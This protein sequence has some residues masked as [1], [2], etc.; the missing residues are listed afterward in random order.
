MATTM[1]E[2]ITE[3]RNA[4]DKEEDIA[5]ANR[6]IRSTHKMKRLSQGNLLFLMLLS[7]V[8]QRAALAADHL[9]VFAEVFPDHGLPGIAP[10]IKVTITNLG[11]KAVVVTDVAFMIE[12]TLP[13]G[14]QYSAG[15]GHEGD[16]PCGD[17]SVPWFAFRQKRGAFTLQPQESRAAYIGVVDNSFFGGG[18]LF[19]PGRYDLRLRLRF[20]SVPSNTFRYTVDQPVGEDV[21]VWL[22]LGGLQPAGGPNTV[23]FYVAPSLAKVCSLHPTSAYSKI[24]RTFADMLS[25]GH[26]TDLQKVDRLKSYIASGLPVGW[27]GWIRLEMAQQYRDAAEAAAIAGSMTTAMDLAEQGQAVLRQLRTGFGPYTKDSADGLLTSLQWSREQLQT[28]ADITN[29][30]NQPKTRE[31]GPM[32]ECVIRNA[33]GTYTAWFGYNNPTTQSCHTPLGRRTTSARTRRTGAKRPCF[34]LVGGRRRLACRSSLMS[35]SCGHSTAGTPRRRSKAIWTS[36]VMTARTPRRIRLRSSNDSPVSRKWGGVPAPR[37]MR[38]QPRSQA[39]PRP[40]RGVAGAAGCEW[41]T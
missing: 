2:G 21:P 31:I 23:P 25:N 38:D 39:L 12:G 5:R 19:I 28:L 37:S 4:L 41:Q 16:M 29:D 26:L 27:E 14:A 36:A 18:P 1:R 8:A 13:S 32:L 9:S 3:R 24:Y 10:T 6:A 35:S 30:R 22:A 34:S 17:Y 20:D 40:A 33:D 7:L 15:C 11:E